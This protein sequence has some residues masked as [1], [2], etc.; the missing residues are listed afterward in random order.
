MS[1][2]EHSFKNDR[3]FRQV[4]TVQ[5]FSWLLQLGTMNS[6]SCTS[7]MGTSILRSMIDTFSSGDSFFLLQKLDFHDHLS[8]DQDHTYQNFFDT[9]NNCK[10]SI[11]DK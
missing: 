1:T 4:F 11:S 9:S 6:T 2:T 7:I 5:V 3:E 8:Y 10:T